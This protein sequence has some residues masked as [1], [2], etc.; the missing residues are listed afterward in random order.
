MKNYNIFFVVLFIPLVSFGVSYPTSTAS[1]CSNGSAALFGGSSAFY[2]WVGVYPDLVAGQARSSLGSSDGNDCRFRGVDWF[3]NSSGGCYSI[4]GATRGSCP[5]CP[6]GSTWSGDTQSCVF[7]PLPTFD[8]DPSGCSKAGGYFMSTGTEVVGGTTYGASFFGGAGIQ[9][10]GSLKS[11]TKCGTLGDLTGQLVTN[12]IGL[13]PFAS[14]LFGS[15][16][17]K[18]LAN[19]AWIDKLQKYNQTGGFQDK[20]G[21]PKGFNDTSVGL[22]RVNPTSGGKP[23][24][25]IIESAVPSSIKPG[26]TTLTPTRAPEIKVDPAYEF[27]QNAHI[28]SRANGDI[29]FDESIV[30]LVN[31][32]NTVS[33]D[34]TIKYNS[35]PVKYAHLA[36]ASVRNPTPLTQIIPKTF[37][38]TAPVKETV[39]F[40]K[41]VTGGYEPINIANYTG[42]TNLVHSFEN[43]TP[44]DTYTTTKIFPDGSSSVQVVRVVPSTSS[45]SMKTTTLAPDGVSNTTTVP[46]YISG[47]VS[48]TMQT[49]PDVATVSTVDGAPVTSTNSTP[50][51]PTTITNPDSTKTTVF[52][53]G[54]TVTKDPAGVILSST[55]ATIT[56]PPNTLQGQDAST[57][58][59]ARMPDYSYQGTGNFVDF[60][61]SPVTDMIDGAS[62]MFSNISTQLASTKTVFDNTK[63]MLQGG[64][65][66]PVIPAG[67]CGESLAFNFHG[68]RI[69]LCPPLVN[70]T[71]V[72]SPIVAPIVTI[73]G[74]VLSVS[75]MLGGF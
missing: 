54:S 16:G 58:I 56:T 23:S 40:S 49:V 51:T 38:Y 27:V 45:G 59:D 69:D 21:G 72:G 20:I 60:I 68:K 2:Q 50:A 4:T 9:L 67:S 26:D 32:F 70:S 42:Q 74:M 61:S 11:T 8:N 30:Q 25:P 37:T 7:P 48:P 17:M 19:L 66:P 13:V 55:P 44:I 52:P 10:G 18:K 14:K 1:V 36:P 53:D 47:Y 35:D 28:P 3:V 75:I 62:L 73:G 34:L 41:I 63:V 31:D 43:T 57:I 64:W 5:S 71:A 29:V 46:L 24:V 15:A 6:S 65:T 33:R 12:A 22:P 39:D